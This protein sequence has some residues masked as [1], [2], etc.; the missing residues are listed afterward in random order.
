MKA[1]ETLTIEDK[2]F[3]LVEGYVLFALIRRYALQSFPTTWLHGHFL[4]DQ[5]AAKKREKENLKS[6]FHRRW[7]V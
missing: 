1:P 5:Q 7:N 3:L 4:G 6:F 2:P